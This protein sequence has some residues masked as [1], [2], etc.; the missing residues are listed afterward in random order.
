M[1]GPSPIQLDTGCEGSMRYYLKVLDDIFDN[2]D[3]VLLFTILF[4]SSAFSLLVV[5]NSSTFS[6]A[7]NEIFVSPYY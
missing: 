7:L 2:L 1:S 6:T 3:K 4:K 5:A